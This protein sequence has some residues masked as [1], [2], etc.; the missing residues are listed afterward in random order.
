[1]KEKDGGESSNVWC[2]DSAI[3]EQEAELEVT[4]EG[5]KKPY[6][7]MVWTCLEEGSE[8]MGRRLLGLEV[9]SRMPRGRPKRTRG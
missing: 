5:N 7:Q 1:M 8:C 9:P 4:E 3:E 6:S 2:T